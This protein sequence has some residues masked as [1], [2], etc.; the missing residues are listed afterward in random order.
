MERVAREVHVTTM[1]L[2]RYFPNKEQLIE[3]M[4]DLAGGPAP[5][6]DGPPGEWRSRLAEWTHRCASIYREHSWF[7]QA[8]TARRRIMGPNELEWFDAALR[9][10]RDTGLSFPD[11]WGAFLALIGHVRSNSEFSS[12]NRQGLSRKQ[13]AAATARLIADDSERYPA[14]ASAIRSGSIGSMPD[15]SDFGLQCILEGIASLAN[16]HRR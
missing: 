10:L 8:A 7:L 16:K 6:L 11:Q 5:Q 14:L 13:W 2:Y 1:A 3:A 4:I 15:N 12:A 9:V